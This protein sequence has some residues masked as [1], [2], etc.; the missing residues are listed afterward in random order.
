MK[1]SAT[2][3]PCLLDESTW[4]EFSSHNQNVLAIFQ[5]L[6]Q[7][8]PEVRDDPP[9]ITIRVNGKKIYPLK[10]GEPL[11]DGDEVLIVQEIGDI[12][13]IT[14]FLMG[15]G[16]TATTAG[17]IATVAVTLYT[18]AM[19]ASI[20]YTIYSYATAP[21]APSTGGGLNSSP[22]YGWDGIQMQVRP[23]VPVPI[24]YG[25]HLIGGHTKGG[26]R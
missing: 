14:L 25:E 10:W 12:F 3:I 4:I 8:Y 26:Q 9:C 22:T 16:V 18:F 19:V 13:S 17:T 20:A 11:K 5:S 23:G 15:L 21:K 1:I 24:V 6:F 7:K 2:Y